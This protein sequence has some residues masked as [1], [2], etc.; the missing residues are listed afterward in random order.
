MSEKIRRACDV[1]HAHG[2]QY[3]WIDSCCI[4]KTSS[5]ELSEAINSMF[6]WYQNAS[7]CYAF[8]ADVP[9]EQNP[10]AKNSDFGRSRWFTRGWTLQELIAPRS[11]VFLS[12]DWQII[13]TKTTLANT[14]EAITTIPFS[15]LTFHIPLHDVSVAQRMSWASE[16]KTT[17][18]EDEAYSLMGIFDIN[19][20]TLYGEGQRA[21]NRLQEEI[22]TR[23]P[24]QT[25]FTWGP[26]VQHILHVS[27]DQPH[28]CLM[29]NASFFATSVAE[30]ASSADVRPISHDELA[31]RIAF[32]GGLPLP[33]YTT[34][35][36][37]VHARLPLIPCD[38]L[39]SNQEDS[40]GAVRVYLL[41]LACEL[42]DGSLLA[43]M[44]HSAL[45]STHSEQTSTGLA[46]HG[47]MIANFDNNDRFGRLVVLSPDDLHTLG[48][49]L[50]LRLED[51]YLD[52]GYF[53]TAPRPV[54][55]VSD[56]GERIQLAPWSR[57]SVRRAGYTVAFDEEMR[58]IG[59]TR[60]AL[61]L[62]ND[63]EYISIEIESWN[64]LRTQ[65]FS[66]LDGNAEIVGVDTAPLRLLTI[67]T[68]GYFKNTTSGSVYFASS[69]VLN[70]LR[71]L[72]SQAHVT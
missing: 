49:N 50:T 44:C 7:V 56:P 45:G 70:S 20:P 33:D 40:P 15:V 35:S 71:L 46:L 42:S 67:V 62:H 24:D 57:E 13:G 53:K 41:V 16:R 52:P 66:W 22:L 30:F 29:E 10:R 9:S 25:L 34:S 14:I 27:H 60:S 63:D 31:S 19:M 51:V 21:F 4:D 32:P 65:L 12:K 38:H 2:Y 48:E 18:V 43:V 1:A 54:V 61:V 55:D 69:G 8:L 58:R 59:H 36:Y 64:T 47:G 26:R 37:G 5:A 17:R 23:I 72:V 28:A 3:I 39:I 11:V 68:V 6:T